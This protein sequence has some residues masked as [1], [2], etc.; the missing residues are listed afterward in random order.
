MYDPLLLPE[1]REMLLESDTRAMKE[2]CEV[3]YPGVVAE[4]LE[5]LTDDEVWQILTQTDGKKQAEIFEFFDVTRQKELVQHVDRER[6][7]VLIGHMAPD[8]RA[9]LLET[10]DASQVDLLLPLLAQAERADIRK[11]LAYPEHSAGSIMTTDYAS[12]PEGLTTGE[13]LAQLRLQAPDKETIYYIYV[14]DEHRRL[15]GFLSLRKLILARPDTP[16]EKIL[17]RD[18]ISA[19]VDE[20][21]EEVARKIARYDFIAMPV[22]DDQNRLVGI[23][24]HDDVLDVV[25]EEATED[26]YRMG[27]VAPMEENYLEASFVQV[28][29]K[30]AFWLSCLFVAELFTFTA[31]AHFEHAIDKIV[32]LSLF[33]PLCI[34]TGGNSGSQAAT[35]ICRALALGQIQLRDWWRIIRHEFWMG[36]AL[37]LTLGTIGYFRA[38][39][40]PESI[41]NPKVAVATVEPAIYTSR[42]M[43]ALVISQSV[44]GICVWG[45]LVGSTLPLIFKRFGIDPGI[46]SSPF[47]ATFVDVTGIIIYFTI[48][49]IY[50][51]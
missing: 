43:L 5:A 39:A 9:D 24:T 12:L 1:L 27:G 10:L 3:L 7:S 31:L 34:S 51:L 46:A 23:I 44:A 18:V 42:W 26:A 13:A 8:N 29:R 40:T 21:Q 19:R 30:R 14:V 20:D 41:L 36:I 22:V 28:W 47:V 48:A 35:L 33:L 25:Q 2:F 49:N 17:E 4:N 37:G 6:L 32:V 11:L 15:R 16:V 50:L 38:L 45:T